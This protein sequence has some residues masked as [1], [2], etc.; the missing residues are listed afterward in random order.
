LTVFL[1]VMECILGYWIYRSGDS[2]E[3]IVAGILM[4]VIF[5]TFLV[6]LVLI[7]SKEK[8]SSGQII[9]PGTNEKVNPA[10]N[11]VSATEIANATKEV[12]PGPDGSYLIDK[13]PDNW[14][15]K[16]LEIQEWIAD[17]LNI[18][19]PDFINSIQ[20]GEPNRKMLS[21]RGEKISLLIPV[22]GTSRIDGQKIPTALSTQIK[23]ELAIL[24][25]SRFQPPLFVE[26]SMEHNFE[27]FVGQALQLGVLTLHRLTQGSTNHGRRLIMAEIKQDLENV[28]LD[29]VGGRSLTFNNTII[30]IEGELEDHLLI[31]KYPSYHEDESSISNE[32]H[33]ILQKLVNSFRPLKLV[34][35]DEKRRNIK[36]QAEQNYVGLIEN[37]GEEIFMTE[38]SIFCLRLLGMDLDDPESRIDTI[39]QLKIFKTFADE[40]DY[41]DEDLDRLWDTL[42]EAEKG[43]SI[44]LKEIITEIIEAIREDETDE[45]DDDVNPLLDNAN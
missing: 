39:K 32:N 11:E 13:P 14:I 10:G 8:G 34:N 44:R 3:R 4:T 6:A 16:E 15:I 33:K 26:R 28:I 5:M 17:N 24:P 42:P 9:L 35:A 37:N 29:G 21:L 2:S 38:F 45:I 43:N 12:I 40:V 31:M 1:S 30:G 25:M 22:P 27:L 18:K 36:N 7:W 19:D 23:T 41:H 20:I